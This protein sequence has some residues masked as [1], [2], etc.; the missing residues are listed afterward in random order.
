MILCLALRSIYGDAVTSPCLLS[1]LRTHLETVIALSFG[2]RQRRVPV[3]LV[4]AAGV[5]PYLVEAVG[6]S[7]AAYPV[8]LTHPIP[9]CPTTDR[10]TT[11]FFVSAP[12]VRYSSIRR[13]A[14]ARRPRNIVPHG[15]GEKQ[16]ENGWLAIISNSRSS[17]IY[18]FSCYA[19]HPHCLAYVLPICCKKLET[20]QPQT[21]QAG[22]LCR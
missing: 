7:Q 19:P 10:K 9:S 18:D 17:R 22:H 2:C 14:A 6:L 12:G 13:N 1:S 20:R 5:A 8:S 4:N 3:E 21:V 15:G 11:P 16:D